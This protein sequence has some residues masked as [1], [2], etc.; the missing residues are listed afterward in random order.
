M[1]ALTALSGGMLPQIGL[2]VTH[3]W[4]AKYEA[5][6]AL[7]FWLRRR[8]EGTHEQWRDGLKRLLETYDGEWVERTGI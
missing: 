2:R 8:V 6:T 4:E 3:E 1:L 5:N 7:G